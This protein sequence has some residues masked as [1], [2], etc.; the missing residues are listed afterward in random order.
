LLRNIPEER[1]SHLRGASLKSSGTLCNYAIIK[2]Q[3]NVSLHVNRPD[4][5]QIGNSPRYD[6]ATTPP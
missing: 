2:T 3:F 5:A 6:I 1:N 4:R